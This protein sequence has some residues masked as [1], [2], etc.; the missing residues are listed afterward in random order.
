ML[1]WKKLWIRLENVPNVFF[2]KRKQVNVKS[3]SV[4]SKNML[5]SIKARGWGKML[6]FFPPEDK[7][8]LGGRQTTQ[9]ALV[10]LSCS[11]G[12]VMVWC[13]GSSTSPRHQR[14]GAR[15]HSAFIRLCFS[16]QLQSHRYGDGT[17]E[18]GKNAGVHCVLLQ[19]FGRDRLHF[20]FWNT[21]PLYAS[22]SNQPREDEWHFW[23][24]LTGGV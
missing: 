15:G 16:A 2:N 7:H 3:F 22:Q 12:S 24:F 17:N 20:G 4:N 8:G 11:F 6:V 21:V 10:I 9:R 18:R 14:P 19:M 23:L 13:F 1:L 5:L